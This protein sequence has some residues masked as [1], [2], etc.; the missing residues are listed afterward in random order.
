MPTPSHPQLW[1]S[2][3]P[4]ICSPEQSMG[5]PSL[6]TQEV[7]RKRSGGVEGQKSQGSSPADEPHLWTPSFRQL[8]NVVN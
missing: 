7:T 3:Q 6:G 8:L 2:W 1:E 4:R 5:D